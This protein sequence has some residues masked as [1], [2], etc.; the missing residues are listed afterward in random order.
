M[1]CHRSPSSRRREVSNQP[2]HPPHFTHS[3]LHLKPKVS[4]FSLF[5]PLTVTTTGVLVF[6]VF[7]F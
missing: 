7:R 1:P 2:L 4:L 3:R 6:F 5:L